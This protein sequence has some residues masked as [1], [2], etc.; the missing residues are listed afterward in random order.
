MGLS[1]NDVEKIK[2]IFTDRFLQT[3]A[4]RVAQVL[5]RKY[6]TR[7][8]EQEHTIVE[9]K[10]EIR[11]LRDTQDTIL[12]TVDDQEQASR[13][14]NVRDLAYPWTTVIIYI[15]RYRTFLKVLK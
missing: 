6:E 10:E 8:R 1:D 11:D 14:L 13:N 7:L 3:I 15:K 2:G 9:L 5:E 4:E 12:W